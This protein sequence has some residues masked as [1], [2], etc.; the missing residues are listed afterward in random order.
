MN[1]DN[2]SHLATEQLNQ[3][4]H[5]L[6]IK[7]RERHD[8]GFYPESL[9]FR[10]ELDKCVGHNFSELGRQRALERKQALEELV[11]ESEALGLYTSNTNEKPPTSL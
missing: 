1:A 4:I 7:S 11:R 10:V 5:D 8:K 9:A 6:S 2:Y 3:L